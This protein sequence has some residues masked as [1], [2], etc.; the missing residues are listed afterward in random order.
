MSKVLLVVGDANPDLV[1]RG[2]VV[3]RFGQAEQLLDA[4]DL[5]LGGSAAIMAHGAARLGV[6]TRLTAAVGSDLF[7]THVRE[8]LA[9]A[10]VFGLKTVGAPTGLSVILSGPADRAILTLPGAIDSLTAGDVSLDGV[11]HLHVSSY[12]LLPRLAAGLP[13]VFVR[14][15]AAGVTTSLDTNWDP[16]GRWAGVREL[17][18]LTDVFFPNTAELAALGVAA[19][20]LAA[21]G[22]TV[23]VKEGAAGA[24][25]W[26]PGGGTCAVPA[27]PVEVVDTTG[28]GDSFDA[29]FLAGFLAGEPVPR[30]VA[31]GVVA[32]SLSTRAAGGTTAQPTMTELL[33]A[34]DAVP[35]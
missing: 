15:R 5:V 11:A 8:A 23:V 10:D 30:C 12:F 21:T 1:L 18:P 6:R 4:A 16:A 3:P 35:A 17:L 25:A 32:G 29:G 27:R 19:P 20:D 2:D 26:W 34:L 33:A 28:A 9:G 31:M 22:T 13:E 14:A 24:R 7:G